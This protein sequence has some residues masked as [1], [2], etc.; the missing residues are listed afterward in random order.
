MQSLERECGKRKKSKVWKD[1][2]HQTVPELLL[3][4]HTSFVLKK[5]VME[6]H[7]YMIRSGRSIERGVG[8]KANIMYV[9]KEN[10]PDSTIHICGPYICLFHNQKVAGKNPTSS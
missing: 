2:I 7:N 9:A 3:C 6:K 8:Y 10:V 4:S 1:E 5:I